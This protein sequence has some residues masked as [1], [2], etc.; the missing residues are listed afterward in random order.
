MWGTIVTALTKLGQHGLQL[1]GE[2]Q[3]LVGIVRNEREPQTWMSDGHLPG[4][5]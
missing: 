4:E 1:E 5:T 3:T 2:Q